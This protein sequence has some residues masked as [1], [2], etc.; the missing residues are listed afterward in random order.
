[1]RARA[2]TRR[3]ARHPLSATFYNVYTWKIERVIRDTIVNAEVTRADI[4][5]THT[6]YYVT[7]ASIRI[8]IAIRLGRK[9]IFVVSTFVLLVFKLHTCI[10][11][12]HTYIYIVLGQNRSIA[13][14]DCVHFHVALIRFER[15]N[16]SILCEMSRIQ[17]QSGI[18]TSVSMVSRVRAFSLRISVTYNATHYRYYNSSINELSLNC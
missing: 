16:V 8:L 13:I 9:R 10:V 14:R 17:L 2:R 5:Y 11:H 7:S 12:I 15:R 4:Q 18:V 6:Y 3:Y 1:M